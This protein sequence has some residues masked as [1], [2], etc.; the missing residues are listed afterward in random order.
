[1][2]KGEE[3][4]WIEQLRMNPPKLLDESDLRLVCQRVKEILVEEN[5]V[6]SI[7]PPVII[8]G[9]IHGQFFD[10]L[11]LFD[12]GGDIMN[13]D[14]IF[15][16]DYVD[17]GYNSVETFE[18]LLLLKLL[19]PKNITL[20]RGNHESRQITTVYGFYDECFKKYGNAN[21][22]KYC[23]DIF[24]YLTL[25]ALVDNQIFCVHGGL[26]PEIK[27]IDQLRLINRV[28]EIPHEGAFGDIMWSDPDE[29]DD[30]VANP[31]GAGWLF[32]PNVTKKFN[33]INNLELIARAHQLAMEGYRYMFEDSTI[34]TVWSAPNYCYRCGNVAA[35]MRIDEYMNR[36]MLI[37]KDTPDS[38]NSI[39]NKATIPY[40]L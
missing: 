16:G 19:F 15:L 35:I 25:A 12:V 5:N 17:R 22:W 36:Q 39:K 40:F 33:H 9:D 34:I 2:A 1:M 27:L 26:S 18:Y 10:L 11:E 14:Y 20:L 24:D 13:N 23:T 21:A 28:Q 29:V 6:Q 8:C 3:R 31:R 32:G 4:K 30:W 7:K 38:R 37:F